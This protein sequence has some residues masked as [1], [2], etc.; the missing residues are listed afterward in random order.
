MLQKLSLYANMSFCQHIVIYAY[1]Y[2][3]CVNNVFHIYVKEKKY[4]IFLG[5]MEVEIIVSFVYMDNV[6]NKTQIL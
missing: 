3:W 4:E 2:K 6:G 5:S 1:W